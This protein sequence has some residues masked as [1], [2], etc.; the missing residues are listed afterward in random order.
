MTD[1][2]LTCSDDQSG[3]IC[4]ISGLRRLDVQQTNHQILPIILR[5]D[6][7]NYELLHSKGKIH[8]FYLS[9]LIIMIIDNKTQ[10]QRCKINPSQIIPDQL[11]H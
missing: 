6:L 3:D 11:S 1:V 8:I 4:V 10:N 2:R 7:F 9:F 5:Y